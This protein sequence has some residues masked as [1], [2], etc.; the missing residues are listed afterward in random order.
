MTANPLAF[1]KNLSR[2]EIVIVGLI[3]VL[4]TLAWTLDSGLNPVI[5]STDLNIMATMV[6]KD[7]D[8]TLYPR[9]GLFASDE[10]YRLYTPLYRWI[11]GKAW[12]IGGTFEGGLAW[13]V[14]LIVITYLA[15]MFLLLYYVSG[16]IWLAVGVT[17][18]SA[19]Y[20]DT[21]GAGVWGVGGSAE[22]MSRTLFM[23]VIPVLMLFYLYLL[24]NPSWLKGAILGLGIGLATNLHPVSGLHFLVLL[25]AL[26]VLIHGNKLV[27]WLTVIAMGGMAVVGAWPVTLNYMQNSGQAVSDAVQFAAFS[28]IVA[29]RYALFF[30]PDQVKWALFDLEITR[31]TLDVLVWI[32]LGL[33]LAG[34][35]VYRLGRQRWPRLARWAWLV[36]GLI[37]VFYAY[38]LVLFDTTFIFA[39]IALYLSYCFWRGTYPLLTVWLIT[40]TGLVV[41]YMFVGYYLLTYIWQTFEIWSLTSLLIE[42]ARAARFVYLPA[43]LLVAVAGAAWVDDLAGWVSPER[44]WGSKTQL[45]LMVALL[46][47]LA[48]N[49]ARYYFDSLVMTLLA[50][51][52]LLGAIVGL[53]V[54]LSKI[55]RPWAGYVALVF[56]VLV[57]FGP[58]ALPLAK[59]WPVP[60]RNLFSPANWLAAPT[61]N[62]TDSQLYAWVTENTAS[63]ALFL[64]CFG[65]E[66]MTY[67]RRK[68]Q[69]SITHNWKDLTFSVHQRANLVP[70][71]TR[72]RELEASCRTFESLIDMGHAMQVD[73]LLLS[74]QDATDFLP[75]ACFVNEK[76]A[77]FALNPQA[78]PNLRVQLSGER[79]E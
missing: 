41:L 51:M 79:N 66:T 27:G 44:M 64:G 3:L 7:M 62:E 54:A 34:A 56:L 33:C 53:V 6:S 20:H 23:P 31:P 47:A 43:Y 8:P 10:I 18:A 48:P 76:Y 26:L 60:T 73:Y 25:S 58:L 32:Y 29:E 46:F 19:H 78:C 14:P 5:Q 30:Y 40:L 22:L 42:F 28:Y 61:S 39:V 68:T 37:T 49:V 72:F 71:Y 1:T 67:F 24:K 52:L 77:V 59:Y 35:V 65:P 9:D 50:I 4:V 38:M 57:L 16:N 45:S 15:G 36:G 13:L 69:R 12:L 21:M 2:S 55:S 74:S 17:V 70:A 63:D 75:Q 11:I